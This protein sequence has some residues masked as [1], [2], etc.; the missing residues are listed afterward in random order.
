MKYALKV[1]FQKIISRC[2]E[3]KKIEIRLKSAKITSLHNKSYFSFH[4]QKKGEKLTFSRNSL[5]N[6]NCYF[7][8]LALQNKSSDAGPA[9]DCRA[10]SA[11]S[12]RGQRQ[13]AQSRPEG[14]AIICV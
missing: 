9:A 5:K 3:A 13:P 4:S 11:V 12:Q 1:K 7:L 2:V 6:I 10:V 8:I 14:E